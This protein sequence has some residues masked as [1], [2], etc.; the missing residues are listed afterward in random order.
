[1][2]VFT[3]ALTTLAMI[4]LTYAAPKQREDY[5]LTVDRNQIT[6][7]WILTKESRQLLFQVLTATGET[8]TAREVGI[9]TYLI[10]F[11][12]DCKLGKPRG[13]YDIGVMETFPMGGRTV[14]QTTSVAFSWK[15]NA[16]N[17]PEQSLLSSKC[18][19]IPE[20]RAW[21]DIFYDNVP[22]M[23]AG[24]RH[25]FCRRD[26]VLKMQRFVALGQKE[27]FILLEWEKLASE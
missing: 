19:P 3:T 5:N 9:Q 2:K 13:S 11:A 20:A 27:S 23:P 10:A 1:M 26:S 17:A 12:V 22:D 25:Y 6:G 24:K 8:N 14:P 15:L 18:R 4:C 7:V 21:V 16:T